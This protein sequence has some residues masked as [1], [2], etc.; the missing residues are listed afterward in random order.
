M[1]DTHF[2]RETYRLKR[3][4]SPHAAAAADGVR[5]E[6]GSFELP[7]TPDYL[8]VEGA[9]G[10]IVP[11]N[12]KEF[13]L[14]LMMQLHLPIL[15]VARN[16]LGTINHTMLSLDQ[17]RRSGLEV[18]GVVMNGA[19]NT[20]NRKA[21]EHYGKVKVLAE[22]EPLPQINPEILRQTFDRNF[23]RG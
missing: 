23:N 2:H 6:L 9:G 15:L 12:K 21:I 22:I 10:I 14:D 18:F 7:E 5:I 16:G 17:L 20:S 4:L 3:P 19:K 11:L 8:I 1:P 13:M